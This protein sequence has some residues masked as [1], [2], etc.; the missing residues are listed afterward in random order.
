MKKTIMSLAVVSALFSAGA[1]AA[2][3]GEG[4]ADNSASTAQLNFTGKVT[5]SLCQLKTDDLTK[6]ISLGEVSAS[7]LKSGT[8]RAPSHSF[9]VTLENCDSSVNQISYVIRDG[10]GSPDANAT[11]ATYLIPKSSNTSAHGVGVFIV[12]PEGEAIDIGETKVYGATQDGNNGA[13]ASQ[14]ISLAA[15]IGT[16]SGQADTANAVTAGDVEATGIMT[17]KATAAGTAAG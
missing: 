4:K 10:N 1:M 15:Y 11:T 9:D 12:D 6:V 16:A 2:L 13:L 8:G 5:S 14:T 7:Q 3:D 17:I